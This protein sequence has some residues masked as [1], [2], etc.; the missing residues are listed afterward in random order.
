MTEMPTLDPQLDAGEGGDPEDNQMPILPVTK[1]KRKGT[2]SKHHK[3]TLKDP[4]SVEKTRKKKKPSDIFTTRKVWKTLFVK[5]SN[6]DNGMH[7]YIMRTDAR[8]PDIHFKIPFTLITPT[9]DWMNFILDNLEQDEH[10]NWYYKVPISSTRLGPDDHFS[11]D[12]NHLRILE[13]NMKPILPSCGNIYFKMWNETD[14]FQRVFEAD[15]GGIF[16]KRQPATYI[17]IRMF[18]GL[19]RSLRDIL[20]HHK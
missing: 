1:S 15:Q 2:P 8:K 5:F 14:E 19:L 10:K 20:S 16:K 9:I 6:G 12:G 11:F 7:I 4:V 13:F 17:G 3:Y 18:K